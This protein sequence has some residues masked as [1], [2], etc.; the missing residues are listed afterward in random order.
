VLD[1][2]DRVAACDHERWMLVEVI[3]GTGAELVDE[4][5]QCG[6]TSFT[7]SQQTKRLPLPEVPAD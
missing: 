6:A 5:V 1:E 3:L 4:C 2:R 7:A